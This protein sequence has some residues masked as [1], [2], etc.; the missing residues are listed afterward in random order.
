MILFDIISHLL[1]SLFVIVVL[2]PYL[3][4]VSV[5]VVLIAVAYL[6]NAWMD[7]DLIVA[8]KAGFRRDG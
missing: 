7:A 8:R 5:F 6:V 2:W 4:A 3:G 1:I